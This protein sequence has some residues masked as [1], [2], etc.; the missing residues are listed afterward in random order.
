M[1]ELAASAELAASLP[2]LA[3][4]LAVGLLIGFEREYAHR[5]EPEKH[6]FAGAR[7]FA[8]TGLAGALSGLADAGLIL[9]AAALIALALLTAVAY[10]SVARHEPGSG[11]TTE[12]ALIVTFFL[13]LLAMRDMLLVSAIGGVATAIIL[14]A[15]NR[16]ERVAASLTAEEVHAALRFLAISVIVLPVLPDEGMG[17][18][19]AL[20]PRHIWL[21][22]VFI[23]GL[24]FLGYWLIR[25]VGQTRGVIL[26]GLAGGLAS[27]T[28]TTLSLSRLAGE[29]ADARTV[30]AGITASNLMMLI[31]VGLLVSATSHR[32]L[33][34]I[35]PSLIAGIA[36]GAV[37]AALMWRARSAGESSDARLDLGNPMELKPAF[38]FAAILAIVSLAAAYGADE[39]GDAGLVVVGLVSGLADVDAIT[40]TAGAQ[41][42]AGGVDA[43]AATLAVLAAVASN[44]LVKAGM[45][46]AIGGARIGAP[47]ALAFAAIVAAGALAAVLA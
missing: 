45:S 40:L 2:N 30:A 20:N 36:A 32:I 34:E 1:P 41:A 10:W 11:G 33:I 19:E 6:R 14:A 44:I 31:R 47:V 35:A 8:L 38:L 9:P 24:S 23:S 12:V 29:G 46:W 15:K 13:G 7:T 42:Q 37:A 17:P 16:V 3:V 39:F 25:L 5:D 22:V 26:T 43:N 27:S 28:A 21:M 4:A 18:Y